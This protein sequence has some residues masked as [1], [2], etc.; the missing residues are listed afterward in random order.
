MTCATTSSKSFGNPETFGKVTPSKV[1]L[2]FS[3]KFLKNYQVYEEHLKTEDRVYGLI[4]RM[5]KMLTHF[6]RFG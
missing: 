3:C 2:H 1:C 5:V 4:M 6:A